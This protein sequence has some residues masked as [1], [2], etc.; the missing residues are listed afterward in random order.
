MMNPFVRALLL[1]ALSGLGTFCTPSS[2]SRESDRVPTSPVAPVDPSASDTPT[3]LPFVLQA[4]HEADGGAGDSA[5]A[6]PE[7]ACSAATPSTRN[8][9]EA[10]AGAAIEAL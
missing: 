8:A 9:G 3:P 2:R 10:T 4:P 1:C 6:P 7:A 5:A